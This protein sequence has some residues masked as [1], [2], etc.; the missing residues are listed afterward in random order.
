MAHVDDLIATCEDLD[1]ED[2]FLLGHSYA[3]AVVG[4]V[5]RRIPETFAGQIYLD[6]MPMEEGTSFLDGFS[7]EGR[8]EFEKSLEV[9]RGTLVWPMPEPLSAQA[10]TEGLTP[11]DLAL[12]R[13]RGTPQPA[14]TFEEKLTGPIQH[15]PFPPCH[16]ISCVENANAAAVERRAFLEKRPDWTY[17]SLPICHW[18]MLSSPSELASV[19]NLISKS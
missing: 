17:H 15:P 7:Q 5:A 12:L 18:P 19:L 6:T 2:A 16:A 14:L 1:L 3:G 4:A 9:S 10:P 13:E 8:D 11:A